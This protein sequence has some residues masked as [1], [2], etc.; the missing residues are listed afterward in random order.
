MK[1]SFHQ[2]LTWLA[3]LK[4]MHQNITHVVMVMILMIQ[5]KKSEQDAE[6]THTYDLLQVEIIDVDTLKII[7]ERDQKK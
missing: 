1:R 6:D 3:C 7:D 4:K 2:K 5:R